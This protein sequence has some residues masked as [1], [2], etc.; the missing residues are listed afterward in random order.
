MYIQFILLMEPYRNGALPETR[1]AFT[2]PLTAVLGKNKPAG[3]FLPNVPLWGYGC[4]VG[5][6]VKLCLAAVFC[7]GG[8]L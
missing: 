3:L 2:S 6:L 8:A 1:P 5:F 7:A 4:Y